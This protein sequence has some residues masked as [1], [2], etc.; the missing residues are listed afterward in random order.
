MPP[1]KLKKKLILKPKLEK[2]PIKVVPQPEIVHVLEEDEKKFDTNDIELMNRAELERNEDEYS[3]LYPNLDDP[4]FNIKIAERKEFH[5]TRYDGQIHDVEEYSNKICNAEF[6][7]SPHQLFV[8]NFLS[9]QTPYNSLLLYHGLGSGKT[10]SAISVAEEMR[11]YLKQMGI[12]QR[13]IVV[14]S[15]N[16]QD[17]FKLQLFDERKLQLIDGLWNIKA[18][19]GNKYLK[20]IN[21]MNMKGLSK[22]KVIS[23]IKRIINNSYLFLGYIEFS[24]Y[25]FKKSQ[26]KSDVSDKSK[27]LII[28][29]KLK[30]LFN[31]RLIIIDEIHNI[32]IS[33]DNQNKRVAQE[34]YKLVKNVDHLRLLL[35]SATPMYNNYKEII[36]L[37]NLMNI[38]DKRSTIEIKDIFNSDGSFKINDQGQ[39]IGREILAR[40]ATG[41]ISFVRGENPYT[42]PYK[43]WPNEFAKEYTFEQNEEPST[44][45]NGRELVQNIEMLSLYLTNIGEIQQ[46]GYDYIIS[47]L[48]AGDFNVKATKNPEDQISFEN[49]EAFGYTLL[50]KPLESLNIVYPDDRLDTPDVVFD[51]RELVG[52]AGLARIMKSVESTSPLSRDRFEYKTDKYG[53]IFSPSEIGKYSGKIKNICDKIIVST[54]VVLIYSQYIDGGL[55]PIALALEELGFTRA[56]KVNSLFKTPPTEK[57]DSLTYKLQSEMDED[58][59]PA[60]YAMITGDKAL[61]PNNV[62]EFKLLTNTDNK[63]GRFVKVILISQAG[64]EGLDFKF[65]RQVHILEPWYNMNR[66]EQI[67]G[68]AVRN[69]SHKDLPFIERNV[70]LYLY[71]SL[72]VD[73]TK[74]AADIYVYRLAE[75]KALQIGLVSR[76]LKEVSVDCILNF[77]QMGFTVE[78]MKQTVKQHLS[79]GKTIDYAIGDRPYTA[80][81]DYMS[82]CSY[83]C[84]PMKIITEEET[85]LDTFSEAFILMNTDKIIQRI[86]DLMKERF[87]YYKQDL[88]SHITVQ[89]QYPL[90]QIN[91]A[92][93][94]L[95]EDK[96]EY[97]TDKYGRLG[98][99]IN[100]NTLYLFQPIE[101]KNQH[102][103]I[104]DRSV[105]LEF[106][107]KT[108]SV[109]LPESINEAQMAEPLLNQELDVETINKL[110]KKLQDDWNTA[111]T[112]QIVERGNKSWY[113][114]SSLVI[115]RFEDEGI[116]REK[117]LEILRDHIV[118]KLEFE[119][120]LLLLNYYEKNKENTFLENLMDYFKTYEMTTKQVRG[121]LLPN[122]GILKLIVAKKE[123]GDI[124]WKLGE[125]E[126]YIDLEHHIVKI[127][128]DLLPVKTKLNSLVGFMINFK[129]EFMVFKVKDL[130]GVRASKALR[131][132]QAGKN[133]T[134]KIL[135]DIFKKEV[136]TT[137][138]KINQKQICIMIEFYLRLFEKNDKDNKS[139]FLTPTEAILVN[140][141]KL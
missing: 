58:F 114:F 16:V 42:F 101:I 79:S 86:K 3:Y 22:E 20:E 141:E 17:N 44:Q 19:T 14:A 121:I 80:T 33:D 99:L 108:L 139:W 63:D 136:Y 116:E 34:L 38:N 105:P 123:Q 26:V 103:S 96:N 113:K 107:R 129:K 74:E 61:S 87:F 30:N 54:G 8:R 117:L 21:P 77:E 70:E 6:E 94:Q 119:E 9:F 73:K 25:I 93:N 97:I 104:Y 133:I 85:H 112:E 55:V 137:D 28:K 98:N 88:I 43:I 135:N 2:L 82:K 134:I 132:D 47:R 81:C 127:K 130:T 39:E 68:R 72:N 35:L 67:I 109:D 41:Y 53:R 62:D 125:G 36:W 50:Q 75:V 100:I 131:V 4:N 120:Q 69:C 40:K 52:K 92:L 59:Y 110:L 84:K 95:V 37:I 78:Q 138:V 18:C 66:I 122:N 76:L 124:V 10:C 51:A 13:I 27:Q 31:N 24:N 111:I 83:K 12:L 1:K 57:I 89:K 32:R 126:D 45:L 5:D 128:N 64:S 56:G 106:K 29:K 102:I 115:K 91:A 60:R 23:Q 140:I 11:D 48:Y 65:I 46:K 15:P 49:M 71:G 118:E 7:L 90:V